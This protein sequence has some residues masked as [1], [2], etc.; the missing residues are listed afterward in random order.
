MSD[1][2]DY[3]RV[4]GVLYPYGHEDTGLA[5]PPDT[6][7]TSLER[8]SIPKSEPVQIE[9]PV[10]EEPVVTP[11]DAP[12]VSKPVV[13]RRHAPQVSKPTGTPSANA[14]SQEII[15]SAIEWG[16]SPDVALGVAESE[17]LRENPDDGFQSDIIARD[18]NREQSFGVF[19]LYLGGGL[20][21]EFESQTGLSVKDPSTIFQQIQWSMEYASKYG[22][23]KWHGAKRVGIK[24]F[25]G[26]GY[27]EPQPGYLNEPEVEEAPNKSGRLTDP[28]DG[29]S[30]IPS[31]QFLKLNQKD[32]QGQADHLNSLHKMVR[33]RVESLMGKFMEVYGPKGYTIQI[34]QSARTAQQQRDLKKTTKG[35][36]G[37]VDSS[38]HV[39]AGAVDFYI[40]KDGVF[41]EG[42]RNNNAYQLLSAL[43]S[44]FGMTNPIKNDVGHFQPVEV[45]KGRKGASVGD[46]LRSDEAPTTFAPTSNVP[47]P[48]AIT[49]IDRTQDKVIQDAYAEE[50]PTDATERLGQIL[51][52]PN[53]W[54]TT[55]NN[56]ANKPKSDP[57]FEISEE[58][59]KELYDSGEWIP[60]LSRARS[61]EEADL[62][63]SD[64]RTRNKIATELDNAGTGVQVAR[65]FATL[66]NPV[67]ALAIVASGPLASA[68]VIRKVSKVAQVA[69]TAV[70]G[71]GIEVGL[72]SAEAALNPHSELTGTDVL[73]AASAGLTIGATVGTLARKWPDEAVRLL[74]NSKRLENEAIQLEVDKVPTTGTS[75]GAAS[76]SQRTSLAD[77]NVQV[78]QSEVGYNAGG[79]GLKSLRV[80]ASRALGNSPNPIARALANALVGNKIGMKGAE[81]VQVSMTERKAMYADINV[82]EFHS[83]F[84]PQYKAFKKAGGGSI[85]EFDL[86]WINVLET[87]RL[88]NGGTPSAPVVAM[89]NA[90]R[91]IFLR[92]AEE[93]SHPGRAIGAEDGIYDPV[94]GFS[95]TKIPDG[96]YFPKRFS[97]EAIQA[98]AHRFGDAMA[99]VFGGAWRARNPLASDALTAAVGRHYWKTIQKRSSSANRKGNGGGPDDV[100]L[101]QDDLDNMDLSPEQM[102]EYENILSNMEDASEVAN[103]TPGPK[104]GRKRLNMD[105]GH[106]ASVQDMQTGEWVDV[107]VSDVALRNHSV[108]LDYLN[109][110]AGWHA[111]AQVSVKVGDKTLVHGLGSQDKFD[112]MIRMV[113][114]S[115]NDNKL[116][117]KEIDLDVD[118]ITSGWNYVQGINPAL[119][120]NETAEG[121]AD[122]VGKA[123]FIRYG[124]LMAFNALAEIPLIGVQM[125]IK[126]MLSSMPTY[127]RIYDSVTGGMK[128]PPG[129][130]QEVEEWAGLTA[131]Q[132]SLRGD[133]TVDIRGNTPNTGDG[134]TLGKVTDVMDRASS[135]MAKWTGLSALTD[136]GHQMAAVA[137]ISKFAQMS[138]G[139]KGIGTAELRSLG[140]ANDA[141]LDAVKAMLLKHATYKNGLLTGQKVH[142]ANLGDWEDA[143]ARSLLVQA[144]R[145]YA[146]RT[147]QAND[148][149]MHHRFMSNTGVKLM[150]KFMS[151]PL[152]AI[153]AQV[154]HQ[155]YLGRNGMSKEATVYL[156]MSTFSTS[157][158]Y[159]V[160][161]G[162]VTSLM[163]A[164]D[165]EDYLDIHFTPAAIAGAS[166]SRNTLMAVY[167][168][169]FDFGSA[170]VGGPQFFN[171]YGGR[172]FG[173]SVF[174]NAPASMIDDVVDGVKAPVTGDWGRIAKS[175]PGASALPGIW[176]QSQL[177][178]D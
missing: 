23:S 74:D 54:A 68:M 148:V 14:I 118:N 94:K 15:R 84:E 138:K 9:I 165:R 69:A 29:I 3:V 81:V 97:N 173:S 86:Q 92:N 37:S 27:S 34:N 149:G 49:D 39:D 85:N 88:P 117:Q 160:R 162:A 161:I 28:E 61:R 80:S 59:F 21:N 139:A 136:G 90:A 151:H 126:N 42:R 62:M 22:W 146:M 152:G 5:D 71:A 57:D 91:K 36:V 110:Q 18:G 43:A 133:N 154:G 32:S 145:K 124:G 122:I 35:P 79:Y 82:N 67:D 64:T 63:I 19:Q 172:P 41:D 106:K 176:L 10:L 159:M 95:T 169:L 175:I 56:F 38:W 103:S 45:P 8:P 167:P 47:E 50:N 53:G 158:A 109:R 77:E 171:P 111:A 143:R 52:E 99:G 70:A 107:N 144:S 98:L 150:T 130:A 89:S 140:F 30:T 163:S 25:Q 55:L 102:D 16:I 115:G 24:N 72:V 73:I 76:V 105:P 178:D 96:K 168:D 48:R 40:F 20:G 1:K 83:V 135:A 125:G 127:R 157:L 104:M 113:R 11:R 174:D 93:L 112:K 6:I 51:S 114:N 12:Q 164:Q 101:D 137:F 108:M 33:P 46:Y 2:P 100:G 134:T 31:L 121:V 26:I 4:D 58:E 128:L 132:M 131:R 7:D 60:E 87:G 116:T 153:D 123:A 78:R 142:K 65:V 119:L 170:V 75:A 66:A 129:L 44:E 17:G 166:L 141:D 155:V 156:A 177:S 13:T 147:I 120:D